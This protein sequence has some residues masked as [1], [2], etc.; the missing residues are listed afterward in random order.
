MWLAVGLWF[1]SLIA[2]A[3]VIVPDVS[4]W[5]GATLDQRAPMAAVVVSVLGLGGVVLS[6]GASVAQFYRAFPQQRLEFRVRPVNDDEGRALP[7]CWQLVVTAG[8]TF[9]THC[10][11]EAAVTARGAGGSEPL[12]PTNGAELPEG[13]SLVEG[14][15]PIVFVPGGPLY[16]RQR[17]PGPQVTAGDAIEVNWTILWWTEREGPHAVRV[18]HAAATHAPTPPEYH[19][20]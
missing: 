18:R 9:I 3:L 20:R 16:P 11:V 15:R 6:L 8:D 14:P 12:P 13:W 7:D 1:T 19:T 10:R 4:P 5:R 2:A 17:V